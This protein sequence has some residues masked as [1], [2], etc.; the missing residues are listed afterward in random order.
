MQVQHAN[1]DGAGCPH[2]QS[3]VPLIEEELGVVNPMKRP[4][5][6]NITIND[7]INLAICPKRIL[8]EGTKAG[9]GKI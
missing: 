2:I 7:S 9:F 4:K 5:G 1:A 6:N 8:C 3:L